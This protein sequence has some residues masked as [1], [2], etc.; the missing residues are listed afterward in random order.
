MILGLKGLIYIYLPQKTNPEGVIYANLEGIN[1]PRMP[2]VSMSPQPLPPL[3]RPTPYEGTEYADITEFR[4]GDA[5]PKTDSAYPVM[6]AQ[7][8]NKDGIG[9]NNNETAF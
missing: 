4:M 8:A 3:K 9:E 1:M 2:K 5:S 6:Q 7:G